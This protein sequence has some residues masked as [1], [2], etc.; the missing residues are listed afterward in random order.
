MNI[1]V[2]AS[3]KGGTGKSTLTVNLAAHAS[4]PGRRTLLVDADPQSSLSLWHELRGTGEPALKRASRGISETLAQAEKEGY[5]WAFV[6]TPP[7]KSAGVA[8]AIGCATL[9]IIPMRPSIFD[10]AAVRDTIELCRELNTPYAVAMNAAPPKRNDTE[11]AVT[12]VAREALQA[13]QVPVWAGQITHRTDFSLAVGSGA[14]AREF[15]PSSAAAT[16]IAQLWIAV[17]K[18]VKAINGAHQTART[19]HKAAA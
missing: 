4:R 11:A 8:E 13:A 14:G 7:N 12:T 10:L 6:D 16:E 15:D 17:E 3:R 9:V 18:S 5:D 2:V 19:M 1:I